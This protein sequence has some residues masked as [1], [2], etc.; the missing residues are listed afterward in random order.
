MA[1]TVKRATG[2]I[3]SDAKIQ[4][5]VNGEKTASV[6]NNQS[7]AVE[8]PDGKTHLKVTQFIT[9]S[10]EVDVRDG[11]IVEITSTKW[12]QIM[13]PFIVFII[14]LPDITYRLTLFLVLVVLNLII[15]GF[16]LNVYNKQMDN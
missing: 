16:H 10:R 7:I 8:I 14:L 13:L 3:G 5:K 12:N 9:K 15:N 6:K 4:I 2:W 11:D 1:I